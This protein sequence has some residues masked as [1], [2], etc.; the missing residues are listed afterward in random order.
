MSSTRS[1]DRLM[2]N[3]NSFTKRYKK[4][5]GGSENSTSK[6]SVSQLLNIILLSKCKLSILFGICFIVVLYILYSSRPSIIMKKRK[7]YDEPDTIDYK[8]FLSYLVL[9]SVI[10]FVVISFVVYK[11][12]FKKLKQYVFTE[13]QCNMCFEG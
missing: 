8:N 6:M 11:L 13:E 9:F 10:L 3:V 12:P 5:F 7:K 1:S 2:N 4:D